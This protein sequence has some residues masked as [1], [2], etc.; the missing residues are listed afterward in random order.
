MDLIGRARQFVKEGKPAELSS[1]LTDCVI[2]RDLEGILAVKLLA[3][4]MYGGDTHNLF[5]K[6]PAAYCLLAWG[7]D[8]LNALVENAL[9]RPTSKNVT[10]AF[11]L[12]ASIADGDGPPLEEMFLPD[13]DLREAVSRAVGAGD[14]S[15]LAARSLL[16]EL[17]LSLED[18]AHVAISAGA[19]LFTLA[20]MD[21]GAIKNLSQALALRWIAVGPIALTDYDNLMAERGGD[22]PAFHSFFEK[23]PLLLHPRAFQ[24][25]GKP[26]FHGQ[27]EP[28]FIIRTYDNR[29]VVVEI[30]TPDKLLVTR[31]NQLSADATHAIDQVLEYQDYLST[32]SEAAAKVFPG[33]THSIGLVVIGRESSLNDR[34]KALLHRQN[35]SRPD[36]AIVGFDT[37]AEIAKAAT[38][39]VIHG[40]PGVVSGLRLP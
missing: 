17:M 35:R 14:N 3:G 32:H 24:V 11:R 18:D 29:Y 6:A 25:W 27:L 33:F 20:L 5:L 31:G 8:G 1:L 21:V 34:Q 30:E 39:N 9:E 4:D 19:S 2:A 37:L 26:D 40:I 22:E 23:N 28:D 15:K 10:L 7:Q 12:L 16:N 38:G 36:V 13:S